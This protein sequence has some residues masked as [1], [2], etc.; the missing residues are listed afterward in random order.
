MP[1]LQDRKEG[2]TVRTTLG[3]KKKTSSKE[4]EEEDGKT[5]FAEGKGRKE[6][7]MM[8][9]SQRS[10]EKKDLDLF[11][12][13]VMVNIFFFPPSVRGGSS[14]EGCQ[15]RDSL[16]GHPVVADIAFVLVRLE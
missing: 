6:G 10:S 4:E 7:R 1:L 11:F 12:G 9:Q 16:F 15:F 14:F 2:A 8:L 3:G 13:W 5:E